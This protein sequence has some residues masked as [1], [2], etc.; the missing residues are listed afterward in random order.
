MVSFDAALRMNPLYDEALYCKAVVLAHDS[1]RSGMLK[2]LERA[3]A[4]NPNIRI[5]ASADTSF[6]PYKNDS[7]FKALIDE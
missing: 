3:I 4:I 7:D 5:R 2:A 1:D 6:A